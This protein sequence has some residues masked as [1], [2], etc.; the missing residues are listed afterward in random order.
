DHLSPARSNMH[1][2]PG[3]RADNDGE[4]HLQ[5]LAHGGRL[6]RKVVLGSA[7]VTVGRT[8]SGQPRLDRAVRPN[9]SFRRSAD[10]SLC[11]RLPA[12]TSCE[13]A[14][15]IGFQFIAIPADSGASDIAGAIFGGI[16]ERGRTHSTLRL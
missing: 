2:A 9:T 15:R 5:R 11:A 1:A 4:Q 6:A 12:E 14:A 13:I 10:G 16:P 3:Q 7:T 8:K